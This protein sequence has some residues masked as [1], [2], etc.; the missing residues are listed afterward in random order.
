[1]ESN[2]RINH[3]PPECI[4]EIITQLIDVEPTSVLDCMHVCS[5]WRHLI[6]ESPILCARVA[7]EFKQFNIIQFFL[8]FT[9]HVP[10]ILDFDMLWRRHDMS[11]RHRA[12]LTVFLL[13]DIPRLQR[14]VC[15]RSL[16]QHDEADW[17][18]ILDEIK[19]FRNLREL[20]IFFQGGNRLPV[21]HTPALRRLSLS[22]VQPITVPVKAFIRFLTGMPSLQHIDLDFIQP[23]GVAAQQSNESAHLPSL[24]TLKISGASVSNCQNI[25]SSIVSTVESVKISLNVKTAFPFHS[26]WEYFDIHGTAGLRLTVTPFGPGT[27]VVLSDRSEPWNPRDFPR[28]AFFGACAGYVFKTYL[29]NDPF[30]SKILQDSAI[31]AD[32]IHTVILK[33]LN[34]T[35]NYGLMDTPDINNEQRIIPWLKQLPR[36]RHLVIDP[37]KRY[38]I[39][40]GID[41]IWP[42]LRLIT[43]RCREHS[44][45]TPEDDQAAINAVSNWLKTLALS[46]SVAIE[47]VG[48]RWEHALEFHELHS[49]CMNIIDNRFS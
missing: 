14:A 46:D 8:N 28:G 41:F 35:G 30:D 44:N 10:Q 2:C 9:Q 49:S 16:F 37:M 17:C 18:G 1:M 34:A 4:L 25:M 23:Q 42:T 19:T 15:I 48:R 13:K 7:F 27:S 47:L 3:L 24:E 38:L 40:H 45:S 6:L 20:A 31:Y 36:P 26:F 32:S 12:H 11:P 22:A 21:I 5:Q 29:W 43:I 39:E 33:A